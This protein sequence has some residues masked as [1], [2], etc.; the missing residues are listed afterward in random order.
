[1]AITKVLCQ[2]DRESFGWLKNGNEYTVQKEDNSHYL[3]FGSDTWWS[4]N[5]F[6]E[7]EKD[8][9]IPDPVNHPSHYTQGGIETLDYI[10][11]KLTEEEFCGYLKGNIFKYVSREGLKNGVEDLKKARFYLDKLVEVKE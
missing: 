10:K 9:S 6:K 1:M 11:A 8:V 7:I 2:E 4:K 5:R 3:L